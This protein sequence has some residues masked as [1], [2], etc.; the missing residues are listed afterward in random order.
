MN[1]DANFK[2]HRLVTVGT[3]KITLIQIKPIGQLINDADVKYAPIASLVKNAL[4]V[5]VVA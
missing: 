3:L 4:R 5:T 2:D 1:V